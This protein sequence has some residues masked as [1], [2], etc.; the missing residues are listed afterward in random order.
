[1]RAKIDINEVEVRTK[2]RAKYLRAIEN[3][4]WDLLP[5]EVYVKSFLR[6]YGSYLGL[7]TR[8]LLD[9]FKRQ[10]E[11]PSDHELRPITPLGRDRDRDRGFR[12]PRVPPWVAIVVVLALVVAALGYVG[13]QTTNKASTTPSTHAATTPRKPARHRRRHPAVPSRVRLQLTPTGQVYVCLVDGAGR[14]LIP[15]LIYSP[16]QTI[17]VKSAAK[18]L[19]TLGNN[20]VQMKA[21]GVSVP[22]SASAGSIGYEFQGR[23]HRVLTAAQQPRCA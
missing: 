1:M 11:A 10:Y 22:V 4:E 21:N 7:D 8:Q 20:S 14:K 2:I 17:P 23:A 13:S 15:G 5:G 12:R 3:E 6:T 16:G 9:D 18:L 19:L